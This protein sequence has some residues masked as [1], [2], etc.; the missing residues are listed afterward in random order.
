M[1]FTCSWPCV[2]HILAAILQC[3]FVR[4]VAIEVK[5]GNNFA[6]LT[7]TLDRLKMQFIRRIRRKKRLFSLL[8]KPKWPFIIHPCLFHTKCHDELQICSSEWNC[9]CFGLNDRKNTSRTQSTFVSVVFFAN[10]FLFCDC[11]LPANTVRCIGASMLLM[12]LRR[13]RRNKIKIRRI[14]FRRIDK[15]STKNQHKMRIQKH[16]KCAGLWRTNLRSLRILIFTQIRAHFA[17]CI[18]GTCF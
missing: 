12:T 2:K 13:N 15:K 8:H 5:C 9:A 11:L 1:C 16:T 18:F 4:C 17:W 10:V 6:N 3:V 7:N 14:I